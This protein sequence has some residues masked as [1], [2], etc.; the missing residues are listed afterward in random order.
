MNSTS[1]PLRIRCWILAGNEIM[2][3]VQSDINPNNF[4]DHYTRFPYTPT[5]S[6]GTVNGMTVSMTTVK[7]ETIWE[8]VRFRMQFGR[9]T[10]VQVVHLP[11]PDVVMCVPSEE[12]VCPIC[13]EPPSADELSFWVGPNVCK[14]GYHDKCLA[15]CIDR[16]CPICRR[17]F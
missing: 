5:T 17:L 7:P 13:L 10:T 14:H 2:L 8:P 6:T 3:K 9:V 4:V 11:A 16:K 15:R 12:D 1:V